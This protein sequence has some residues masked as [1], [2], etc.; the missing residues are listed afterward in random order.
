M[1]MEPSLHKVESELKRKQII[2]VLENKDAR[3]NHRL[4]MAGFMFYVGYTPD[5]VCQ[6]IHDNCVWSDYDVRYTRFQVGC[7][8]EYRHH[9]REFSR[10]PAGK[11]T[12]DNVIIEFLSKTEPINLKIFDNISDAVIYYHFMGFTVLPKAKNE[13]KPSMSWKEYQERKPTCDE[14]MGWDFSNGICLLANEQYSFLD[15][16]KSGYE[17]IFNSRHVERTP[18]GGIHVFGKG[19]IPSVNIEG[20]EIKGIGSLIVTEPTDKY[21]VIYA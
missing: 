11:L 21:E 3:H 6:I 13:K 5:E 16:D 20:A 4:W 8:W 7:V 14:L 2:S 15:L 17:R 19:K 1:T 9:T 18:R 10:L 12:I